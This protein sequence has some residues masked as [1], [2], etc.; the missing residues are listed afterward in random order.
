[1]IGQDNYNSPL[2]TKQ[3]VPGIFVVSVARRWLWL[4]RKPKLRFVEANHV[5]LQFA[6]RPC[7][8]PHWR[9]VSSLSRPAPP[10]QALSARRLEEVG[11]ETDET[12]ETSRGE[13]LA[14]STSWD[15]S[16][17]GGRAA[18]ARGGAR[19]LSRGGGGGAWGGADGGGGA[20]WDGSVASGVG[21]TWGWG[22]WRASWGSSGR[23]S[24]SWGGGA[25]DWL[26]DGARA[27]G[28]GQGGGR[29][30][31]DGA[32]AGGDDGGAWAVGG[33]VGDELSRV[34]WSDGRVGDW[35]SGG[36]TGHE[37]SESD[38]VLHFDCW[39]VGFALEAVV[40][41]CVE[42]RYYYKRK[43]RLVT[44]DCGV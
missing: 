31:R 26:G 36:D 14:G 22:R 19:G 17:W 8:S 34:D 43:V 27:V 13:G 15:G 7:I 1:M 29:R 30:D 10:T 20:S 25:V 42:R 24:G 21:S 2:V 28:D 40:L 4:D 38:G 9:F 16:R 6:D 35:V 32:W 18:G 11:S 33:V 37:G 44:K 3:H 23:G 39:G 5:N 41:R 12:G